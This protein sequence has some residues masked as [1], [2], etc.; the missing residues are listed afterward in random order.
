[1]RG[2]STSLDWKSRP[3]E[4]HDAER[5]PGRGS[6]PRLF[7]S[8]RYLLLAAMA[9]PEQAGAEEEVEK[10]QELIDPATDILIFWR[11]VDGKLLR[12]SIAGRFA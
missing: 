6:P 5:A 3:P 10:M 9:A 12:T 7:Y 8:A 1:M 2:Y 4:T 11:V